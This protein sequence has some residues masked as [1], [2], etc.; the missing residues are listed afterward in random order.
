MKPFNARSPFP[1]SL[2]LLSGL[3]VSAGA[4]APAKG[5]A[6][7]PP[8]SREALA[9][10][11]WSDAVVAS[12]VA[13]DDR[14]ATNSNPPR[15]ELR[16]HEVLRG[17]KWLNRRRATWKPPM[18]PL[19]GNDP[20]LPRWLATPFKGPNAGTKWILWGRV[21]KTGQGDRFNVWAWPRLPY[22]KEEEQKTRTLVRQVEQAVREYEAG[23]AA[24]EKK[25]REAK[26][27]WRACVSAKDL[28]DF[29]AAADFVG[30]G[31]RIS[32]QGPTYEITT[33]LKGQKRHEYR[34]NL[35]F[36]KVGFAKEVEG[37]LDR[38]TDY[39]LFLNEKVTPHLPGGAIYRPVALGDGIVIADPAAL[40][41][42]RK[43]LERPRQP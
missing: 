6:P 42:V 13:V 28:A 25:V 23:R 26:A 5:G 8:L 2:L 30:V 14:K 24:E 32:D 39:L 3:V 16:I 9:H 43:A 29:A 20:E 40:Q 18:G 1:G 37:L 35:Y 33:I 27:R 4:Q 36:V 7:A 21:E 34:D 10:F 22:S 15:L 31:K 19:C 17:D 11:G 12:V 38:E 41:A